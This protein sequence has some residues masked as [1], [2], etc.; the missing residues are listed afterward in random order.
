MD[1]SCAKQPDRPSILHT[2]WEEPDQIYINNITN[3]YDTPK[4]V[5][6]ELE[7]AVSNTYRRL[8]DSRNRRHSTYQLPL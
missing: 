1:T 4:Y 5:V 2:Y 6:D 7:R 8:L 3:Y